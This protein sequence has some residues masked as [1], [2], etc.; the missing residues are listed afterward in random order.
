MPTPGED[1]EQFCLPKIRRDRETDVAAEKVKGWMEKSRP[2]LSHTRWGQTK[3]DRQGIIWLER[4]CWY[5][6]QDGPLKEEA[7]TSKEKRYG[8]RA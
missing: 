7:A 6:L 1:D 3:D 5:M 8:P 2:P 4:L